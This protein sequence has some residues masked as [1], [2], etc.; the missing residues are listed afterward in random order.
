[1]KNE[2]NHLPIV[3]ARKPISEKTIAENVLRWGTGGINIDGCRI[4][5]KNKADENS[6]IPGSLNSNQNNNPFIYY[7]SA[8]DLT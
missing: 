1:M 5:Y 8:E 2:T 4:G 6:S 3:L 7:G